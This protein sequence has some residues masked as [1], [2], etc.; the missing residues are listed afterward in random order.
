MNL[1]TKRGLGLLCIGL[2]SATV[3]A[4]CDGEDGP[5]GNLPEECGL[6]CSSEGILEGNASI[7][8]QASIDAFFSSVIAV[9]DASINAS[10]SMKAELQGMAAS[11]GVTGT[12]D[13]SID[14]LAAA[15]E[16]NLSAHVS[17]YIEGGLVVNYAPAKCEAN[18]DVAVEAT[19]ECDVTVDPGMVSASC[20]GSCEISAEAQAEC[21]ASGTLKCE[22]QAPSF[23]CEG[24]CTGSC[25]L[26]V[27]ASCSG[28]C[29]G[30][31]QGTCTACA[32]GGCNEDGGAVT[33][34]AG[35]CEGTC[36]GECKL[37]AGGE[38]GGKC[39]GSCEYT[40]ASGSCEANATAKCEASA[41]ANIEC[42]GSCEGEVKP[43]EASAECKAAVEAQASASIECTPPSLDVE[44]QFKAGLEGDV[45]AEFKAWLEGFKARFSAMVA[46]N[47]KLVGPSAEADG[48]LQVAI[49]GLGAAASGAVTD[50]VKLAAEGDVSLKEG[51]G[52]GCA[53]D[54]LKN[55]GSALGD[56]SA[57]LKAS[58]SAFVK[59]SGAVGARRTR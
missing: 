35:S 18:L 14:E 50:A 56:A 13:M 4:A 12:A 45:K 28:T 24:S 10:A 44:F 47:A 38:C 30:S 20:E 43:P 39:E 23:E 9:R 29:N 19:A 11:I 40:P 22:G 46:L 58:A 55:V 6:V 54:E 8:G 42:E 5:L 48:G 31:C 32:G 2:F 16:A 34:C 7:S 57:Q 59:V 15:I 33:N 52:L 53:L 1:N 36:Q 3:T 26:E 27:A 51:V 25:Q 21:S 37:E 41:E 17:G 49:S